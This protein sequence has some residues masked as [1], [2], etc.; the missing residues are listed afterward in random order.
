MEVAKE[1][2]CGNNLWAKTIATGVDP[3][4]PKPAVKMQIKLKIEASALIKNTIIIAIVST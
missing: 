4:K 2:A 3:Y 1:S